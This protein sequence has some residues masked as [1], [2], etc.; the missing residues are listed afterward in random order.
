MI[1]G[2]HIATA[3]DDDTKIDFSFREVELGL[4][5]VRVTQAGFTGSPEEIVAK[6]LDATQGF[7]LVLCELKALLEHD[8]T[9]DAVG[10]KARSLAR[11]KS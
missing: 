8:I 4:T 5:L 3:W 1:D 7:A 2:Q 10:D 9:L 6:A 11:A